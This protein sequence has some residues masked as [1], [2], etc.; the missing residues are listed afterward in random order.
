[1]TQVM[2]HLFAEVPITLGQR[3]FRWALYRGR[4]RVAH[5]VEV[6][7]SGAL[8]A[9][10]LCGR[11]AF[12][13]DSNVPWGRPRCYFCIKAL[14]RGYPNTA[15]T[16]SDCDNDRANCTLK[17]GHAGRCTPLGESRP[18]TGKAGSVS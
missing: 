16:L 5:L 3:G 12:P 1:M 14:K 4:Q 2:E 7:G 17:V 11:Y 6:F 8:A 15:N 18:K 9:R 13:I 10:S